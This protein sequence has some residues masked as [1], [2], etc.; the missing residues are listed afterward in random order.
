ME[1]ILVLDDEVEIADLVEIYLTNENYEVKKLYSP[2]AVMSVLAEEDIS[3][4]IIDVM[5]PGIDGLTLCRQIRQKHNIPIIMLSA[6]ALDMDKIMGLGSGADDYITKPFN[7]IE[8]IARVKAQLRRFI[9]LNPNYR[10]SAGAELI[11]EHKGLVVNKENYKVTLYDREIAL[12]PTQM[13]ILFLLLS[14]KGKALSTEEIFEKVWGERY[15][16]A[17]NNTVMVHIRHIREKLGDDRKNPKWIKTV[18]GV[19]YK[20]E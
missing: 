19:G 16:D 18:W 14:H 7:P 2:G 9:K 12:T 3:L 17:S 13:D 6:K 10:E 1:K 4:A 15:F 20:I 8:L 11:L 5:M